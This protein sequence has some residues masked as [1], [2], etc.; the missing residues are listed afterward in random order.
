MTVRLV[1]V[2]LVAALGLTIPG[3]PTIEGWVAA[4]QNWMN[5]RFADWDTRNPQETDYVIISDRYDTS[6]AA[7]RLAVDASPAVRGG[8]DLKAGLGVAFV[9][10]PDPGPAFVPASFSRQRLAF[11]PI[12]PP[13]ADAPG[14]ALAE[15]MNRRNDGIG[16]VPPPVRKRLPGAPRPLPFGAVGTT[17]A[18][19]AFAHGA[20]TGGAA[21]S[22]PAP[23]PA[24]KRPEE[25][26]SAPIIVP[27]DPYGGVAFDLNR[28]NEGLDIQELVPFRREPAA[29]AARA[30]DGFASM[31]TCESLYFDGPTGPGAPGLVAANSVLA[32]PT[33]TFAPVSALNPG[34]DLAV[35]TTD[36]LDRPTDGFATT[37]PI[38]TVAAR[39]FEPIEVGDALDVGVANELNRRHDG[40]VA[41]TDV[42]DAS[43]KAPAAPR[44]A[45]RELSRAVRLTG[46]ALYA[47]V[48]VLTG[49]ALVT[50]S[51]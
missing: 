33:P 18:V 16:I 32:R 27:E 35:E 6:F 40:I 7:P 15:E 17:Y 41:T 12:A 44:P 19:M 38:A 29:S 30:F 13:T 9:R 50:V 2:S 24:A 10:S 51:K 8:P 1:L 43:G 22:A 23:R 25:R 20:S 48:S 42:A 46:E 34:D 3:G 4:T 36:A 45:T 39:T 37:G 31:E 11:T 28:A 21:T 49:P 47:W 5:A 26:R 14:I